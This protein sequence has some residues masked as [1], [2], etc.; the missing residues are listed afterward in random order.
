MEISGASYIAGQWQQSDSRQVFFGFSP[1][2]NQSLTTPIYEATS[3]MLEDALSSSAQAFIEYRQ[4][5]FAQRAT[6]LFAIAQEIEA[7]GDALLDITHEETNLPIARLQGERGRT[8]NQLRAFA[9][10]LEQSHNGLLNLNVHDQADPQR[11]PLAKPSTQL[12]HLPVGVV[13]VFGASNFP[14]AFS[15]LG[16]DT[17]SALAAGCPVIM[18]SHTA[19]P[20]TS[21]MMTKAIDKAIQE[22]KMPKGVFSMIQAKN[23][24]I[25][26]QLV[27]A[28]QIK[29]V[30]FTGSFTVA[31]KLMETISKRSEQIPFYGE[32]GSINPQ[33]IFARHAELH[34][35][36]L[37]QQLCQSLLMGNG[38][39]CTSPGLWLIPSNNHAFIK[40]AK[41]QLNASQSDTLLSPNIV[42]SFKCSI[43]RLKATY[44]V[45]LI[46]HGQL[47]AE[48]HANAHLFSTDATTYL[49]N[50]SLHEEVFGPAALIVTYE[51]DTELAQIVDNLD[52][53]LTASIH[54]TESDFISQ[55]VVIEALQYKVGR[56]IENQM[57]T[58]VEVCASMNHGGPFPSSTDVKSTSVGLNA[59]LRFLRPICRQRA[60]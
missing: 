40:T 8:I 55:N 15:T 30:G 7:L 16:G 41:E 3:Q 11:I 24:D 1:R 22:T 4:T 12:S 18:K 44:G 14:Y 54:G 39:F 38:Q 27:A 46:A 52:G 2:Q 47:Q 50:T 31:Q 6:F 29:A 34:G 53:Q 45:S 43:E 42:N 13:A 19:H 48:F 25:S 49:A 32:L 58:G 23:Y 26:H 17:A 33:V 5:S 60:G 36:E 59:M 10:A 51:N 37:A 20:A 28:S 57:P 21:E 56:L 9:Q 35:S